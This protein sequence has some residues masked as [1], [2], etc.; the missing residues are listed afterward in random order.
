M[1]DLAPAARAYAY[2]VPSDPQDGLELL[3]DSEGSALIRSEPVQAGD[4][5]DL[6]VH[7]IAPGSDGSRPEHV[8]SGSEH[9]WVV[10]AVEA[11]EDDGQR[12]G[13]RGWK[14]ESVPIWAGVLVLRRV[15]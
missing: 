2:H 1:S 9:E 15:E 5:I 3:R 10:V 6:N 8:I 7:E 4:R 11:G 14:R 13:V 12:V